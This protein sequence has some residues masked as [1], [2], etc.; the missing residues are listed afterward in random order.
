MIFE[1]DQHT[2]HDFYSVTMLLDMPL[3]SDTASESQP[4]KS[5]LLLINGHTEYSLMDTQRCL[6]YHKN[7][8][9]SMQNEP[10]SVTWQPTGSKDTW[11]K[12]KHVS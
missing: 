6:T 8:T 10:A 4:P 2:E 12:Q 5:L 1:L 7:K 9:T 11:T 3:N